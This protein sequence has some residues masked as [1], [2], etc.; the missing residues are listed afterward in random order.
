[1]VAEH[2]AQARECIA[3]G[4]AADA[5]TAAYEAAAD[6][7]IAAQREDTTLSYREIGRQVGKSDVWVGQL[8]RWRTT[9][10]APSQP[11][12]RPEGETERRD[13]STTKGVLATAEPEVVE[14]IVADLPP[15]R[16][17]VVAGAVARADAYEGRL[18]TEGTAAEYLRDP[19]PDP[20]DYE[21]DHL[22]LDLARRAR[23]LRDRVRR[24]GV[25]TMGNLG[26]TLRDLDSAMA[27]TG[28]ARAAVTEYLNEQALT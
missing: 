14:R 17:D 5:K 26:D 20:S 8:V 4:D 28:E 15:E 6:H 12:S 21:I 25:R 27:D 22:A 1:M 10:N 3:I 9:A 13:Q 23:E 19:A 11:F 7:I 18:P 2:L 24:Y 16:R